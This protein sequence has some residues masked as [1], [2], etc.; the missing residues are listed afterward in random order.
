MSTDRLFTNSRN[1]EQ[2]FTSVELS[3]ELALNDKQLRLIRR[4]R[5]RPEGKKSDE[6]DRIELA[7]LLKDRVGVTDSSLFINTRTGV[8]RYKLADFS[9]MLSSSINGPNILS[10]LKLANKIVSG[11]IPVSISELANIKTIL[12]QL[13]YSF[14][15]K[16]FD[17]KLE[18]IDVDIM[19][20]IVIESLLLSSIDD[21][22]FKEVQAGFGSERFWKCLGELVN[23]GRVKRIPLKHLKEGCEYL[24]QTQT[25]KILQ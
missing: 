17:L 2:I 15:K 1:Y 9:Q 16:S 11:R 13:A 22:A 21:Y 20:A 23:S 6:A 4:L 25:I 24:D 3:E 12:P 5:S 10:A 7:K 19:L 14:M 18:E 8:I